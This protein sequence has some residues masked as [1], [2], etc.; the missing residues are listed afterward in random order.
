MTSALL[1][2]AMLA[3]HEER[4]PQCRA[5]KLAAEQHLTE[6]FDGLGHII[7]AQRC[8]EFERLLDDL[9]RAVER[10]GGRVGPEIMARE[11]RREA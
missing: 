7:S 10:E 5:A 9:R 3:A 6:Y 4:C 1:A 2:A 11:A 8:W